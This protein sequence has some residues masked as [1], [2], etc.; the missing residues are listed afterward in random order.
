MEKL[1]T[2]SGETLIDY[3]KEE[4]L[5]CNKLLH[6]EHFNATIEDMEGYKY[7]RGR[8]FAYNQMSNWLGRNFTLSVKQEGVKDKIE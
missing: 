3:L 1:V 4:I 2:S 6:G 8:L 5:Q 7:V